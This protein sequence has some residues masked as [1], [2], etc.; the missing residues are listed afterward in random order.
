MFSP[1]TFEL[2]EEVTGWTQADLDWYRAWKEDLRVLKEERVQAEE[3]L[4]QA[5]LAI[6]KRMQR[7]EE[8][9]R[10]AEAA[11]RERLAEEDRLEKLEEEEW[12][13]EQQECLERRAR[14][15]EEDRLFAEERRLWEEELQRED[16]VD[17]DSCLEE[18][19]E[20]WTDEYDESPPPYTPLVLPPSEV[21]LQL[22]EPPLL[23]I[24]A[25]KSN[26]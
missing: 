2:E 20:E 22:Q 14:W 7:L 5:E 6:E 24:Y 25:A 17:E 4:R 15:A 8:E 1:Q 21:Q 26:A 3:E 10:L 19:L 18:E 11:R 23:P 9:E 16:M 13:R 12:E